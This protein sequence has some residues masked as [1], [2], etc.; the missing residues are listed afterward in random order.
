[1]LRGPVVVN[2]EVLPP[3][4]PALDLARGYGYSPEQ[5]SSN[6]LGLRRFNFMK[7]MA[8]GAGTEL[9][10]VVTFDRDVKVME[11][12]KP[13]LDLDLWDETMTAKWDRGS[14]I[15]LGPTL[16]FTWTVETG[17]NDF[18]GIEVRK[19]VL[20]GANIVDSAQ[21]PFVEN[22]YRGVLLENDKIFG[23]F[24]EMSIEATGDAVAGERYE[25]QGQA[26]RRAKPRFRRGEPLC[27][28]GDRRQRLPRDRG[29][30]AS[31][32]ER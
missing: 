12:G 23:G 26:D 29:A 18:D 30:R 31:R 2:V 16:T 9:K 3:R 6:V 10:F 8:H 4:T 17:D 7:M 27:A 24:H 19:L 13:T 14:G 32:R 20:A 28:G 21:R 25:V 15:S 5:L 1:M 22:S 11:T